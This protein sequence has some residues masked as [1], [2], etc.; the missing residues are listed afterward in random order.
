MHGMKRNSW[1][2]E[3]IGQWHEDDTWETPG[4]WMRDGS[5]SEPRDAHN[6][7]V[8]KLFMKA[9][10]MLKSTTEDPLS[11][12]K[13]SAEEVNVRAEEGEALMGET[14]AGLA[15]TRPVPFRSETFRKV[16]SAVCVCVSMCHRISAPN[17]PQERRRRRGNRNEAVRHEVSVN[18]KE[19]SAL[20]GR[21]IIA[22]R[23]SIILQP[24]IVV[25]RK[26]EEKEKER[27]R[28][29]RR[30]GKKNGAPG[31]MPE[32]KGYGQRTAGRLTGAI[33]CYLSRRSNHNPHPDMR[34]LGKRR[35]VSG[36]SESRG[37]LPNP[38]NARDGVCASSPLLQSRNR[39]PQISLKCQL[40]DREKL[41][42]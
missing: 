19:C 14:A 3:I 10:D 16:Q 24:E 1:K 12:F 15:V 41:F 9:E 13:H 27:E 17:Q 30:A 36:L 38:D 39:E 28:K 11:T 37:I 25:K 22:G 29:E 21:Q 18:V 35:S 7:S 23:W 4:G 33:E 20:F 34:S 32:G 26:V 31:Q 2:N 42:P 6:G 40:P 5:T 8:M